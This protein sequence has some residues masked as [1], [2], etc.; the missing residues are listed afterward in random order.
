MWMALASAVGLVTASGLFVVGVQAVRRYE[1]ATNANDGLPV[2]ALPQTPTGVLAVTGDDGRLT[3][4]SIVV[5]APNGLGGSVVELPVT[6]DTMGGVDGE[7]LPLDQA[8]AANGIE[9]LESTVE[10]V[11]AFEIDFVKVVDEAAAAVLFGPIAPIEVD[12]PTDAVVNRSTVVFEQGP[13]SFD[14]AAAATFLVTKSTVLSDR[15]RRDNT[16]AFWNAFV[17]AVGPGVSSA[18]ASQAVD[19]FDRLW[20]HVI[21]GPVGFRSIAVQ[22][23][24]PAQNADGLDV[25]VLDVAD[26]VLVLASIAPDSLSAPQPGLRFKLQ[27]PPGYEAKVKELIGAVIFL[28]GN[29]V[30]VTFDGPVQQQ[31]DLLVYDGRDR[32]DLEASNAILGEVAFPKPT[33][34]I[35]GVDVTMV[36]G[37]AYLDRPPA[38]TTTTSPDA[39]TGTTVTTGAPETTSAP[40]TTS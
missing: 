15:S 38:T 36:L 28:Q 4:V 5:L 11:L 26:A 20:S 8:V 30:V 12:L 32:A 19:S 22:A 6:V 13:N 31:T 34:S 14:A 3:A 33:V 2:L 16:A 17:A 21:A 29:V 37:S 27:A 23:L 39:T 9:S 7:R 25:E 1:A 18:D 35:D 40:D 10:A 24:P